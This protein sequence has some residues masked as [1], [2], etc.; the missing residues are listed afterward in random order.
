MDYKS[1]LFVPVRDVSV[2]VLIVECSSL[3]DLKVPGPQ[4]LVV[5]QCSFVERSWINLVESGSAKTNNKDWLR[6]IR[7]T[8]NIGRKICDKK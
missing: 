7:K 4:D 3:D 2:V 8:V 6:L 1:L 5:L